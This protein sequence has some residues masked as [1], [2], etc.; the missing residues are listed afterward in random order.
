MD[1]TNP[2]W[3]KSSRGISYMFGRDVIDQ[4]LEKNN[5]AMIC[6]AHQVVEDGY[7]FHADR[8]LVTIFSAPN[9][10]GEFDNAGALMVIDE[11]LK[12]SFRIIRPL[13]HKFK[14]PDLYPEYAYN[15][16]SHDFDDHDM[17]HL[18]DQIITSETD[19]EKDTSFASLD[20]SDDTVAVP[21]DFESFTHA[22]P[23]LKL[24]YE[25]YIKLVDAKN[26][27]KYA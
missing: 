9:Y 19:S 21:S 15:D 1:D 7:E 8:K 4:F 2:G 17:A 20:S 18:Q 26:N 22:M 13:S 25:D 3:V 6:R 5:L 14:F 12:C 16:S 24:T 11:N 10:C 23:N 27:K